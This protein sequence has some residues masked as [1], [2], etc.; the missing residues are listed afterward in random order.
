MSEVVLVFLYSVTF[1]YCT[2]QIIS[3]VL[4]PIFPFVVSIFLFYLK[5]FKL[6]RQFFLKMY[7]FLA[8]LSLRC[9]M[10]AFSG[11]SQRGL[12]F[13]AMQ[14]LLMVVAS[15]CGVWALGI[16]VSVAVS[17]GVSSLAFGILL[18]QRSNLYPLH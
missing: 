6:L 12:L 5:F 11:W 3:S 2:L 13:V 10:Q 18:G 17:L 14:G 8:E 7:L 15:C 9:C 1:A 4:L 16:R